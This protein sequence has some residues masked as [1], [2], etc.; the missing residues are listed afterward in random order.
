MISVIIISVFASSIFA[1][2]E[3]FKICS[4]RFEVKTEGRTLRLTYGGVVENSEKVWLNATVLDKSKYDYSIDYSTSVIVVNYRVNVKKGDVF[5]VDYDYKPNVAKV[6]NVKKTGMPTIS[7][8]GNDS[9]LNLSAG[10]DSVDTTTGAVNYGTNLSSN[11]GSFFKFSSDIYQSTGKSENGEKQSGSFNRHDVSLTMGAATLTANYQDISS[12]YT[13]FGYIRNN[14][15][16]DENLINQLEKEKGLKRSSLGFTYDLNE[17]G[18]LS[19]QHSDIKDSDGSITNTSVSYKSDKMEL[20]HSSSKVGD[21]FTRFSDIRESDREILKNEKGLERTSWSGKYNLGT[22]YLNY[23]YNDIKDS[24]GSIKNTLMSFVYGNLEMGYTNNKIDSGYSSFTGLREADRATLANEIGL[25]RTGLSAKYNFTGFG[26]AN[27]SQTII[28]NE[29]KKISST[30]MS[31]TG[32]KFEFSA[33]NRDVDKGFGRYGSL[34]RYA[35]AG[36]WGMEDG[37]SKSVY[38]FKYNMGSAA[39]PFWQTLYTSRLNGEEGSLSAN[40]LDMSY[41]NVQVGYAS[42]DSSDGFNKMYAMD[43]SEKNKFSALAKKMFN[44]NN[45]PNAVDDNDRNSWSMQSGLDRNMI[46]SKY[47][48]SPE[49][50]LYLTKSN[51]SGEDGEVDLVKVNYDAKDYKLWYDSSSIDKTFTKLASLTPVERANFNNQ[52]GMDR[53]R[54]G[55]EGIT[56]LGYIKYSDDTINDE[57]TDSSYVRNSLIYSTGKLTVGRR[58][59]GYDDNFTRI[60]DI[61]DTD[62]AQQIVNK[63][64]DRYEY[65]VN[66]QMGK[67]NQ[68]LDLNAYFVD[69]SKEST[70]EDIDMQLYELT[71]KPGAEFNAYLYSESYDH[72]TPDTDMV[73]NKKAIARMNKILSF[74]NLKNINLY[75]QYYTNSFLDGSKNMV[76]QEIMDVSLKSDQSQKFVLNLDYKSEDYDNGN[77]HKKYDVYANQKISDKFA[78]TFGYGMTDSSLIED[79]TRLKYGVIY[80]VNNSFNLNYSVD[81]KVGGDGNDRHTQYIAINGLVP[82]ILP[83][84]IINNLQVHAKYDTNKIKDVKDR[85]D[86]SYK[87]SG[88]IFKGAFLMEKS[89]V[90]EATHKQWYVETEKLSYSNPALFGTP[91]SVSVEQ[92]GT[93]QS[94]GAK[95]DTDK[96]NLSYAVTDKFSAI[97]NT[98]QGSWNDKAVYVPLKSKEFG[99]KHKIGDVSDI[100]L[101][102]T[103]NN[104]NIAGQKEEIIGLNYDGKTGD[105][106]GKWSIYAGVNTSNKNTGDDSSDFSYNISYEHKINKEAFLSL[107]TYKTTAVQRGSAQDGLEPDTF[108]LGFRSSF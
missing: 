28:E 11:L 18:A 60:Y 8:L 55:F 87:I 10:F 62:R 51:I 45:D 99:F 86:S 32:G 102:Y 30:N 36:Q 97:Y 42:L 94:S 13:G 7:M 2:D 68:Q 3:N 35:E 16:I 44:Y 20:N 50:T 52:Y 79:E 75:T 41:K 34:T 84:N 107:S 29:D 4:D 39:A 14:S 77:T 89:D 92:V 100:T 78:L 64:F 21:G 33:L 74:G 27:F 1:Q 40:I 83:E 106:K 19:V 90:L 58:F 76:E 82:K 103:F 88:E 72:K 17:A 49:N 69:A 15:N 38:Q 24:G 53:S 47:A 12:D 59:T 104:N 71:Y 56:K 81:T 26:V 9:A 96:Y 46:Y 93:T 85:Y 48:L 5:Y 73:D 105:Q 91:L 80:S 43:G 95:G 61:S 54:Y 22:G 6:T 57:V 65:N 63:G 101:K 37:M 23:A 98:V 31:L 70:K 25:E 108:M 66:M 67:T